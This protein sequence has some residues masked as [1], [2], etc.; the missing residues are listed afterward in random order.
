MQIIPTLGPK[1]CKYYLHWAIWI[2]REQNSFRA[3]TGGAMA[4]QCCWNQGR[5]DHDHSTRTPKKGTP[6][7]RKPAYLLKSSLGSRGLR[8]SGLGSLGPV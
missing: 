3:H 5:V 8:V 1:V 4:R 2:P 6:N 7:F